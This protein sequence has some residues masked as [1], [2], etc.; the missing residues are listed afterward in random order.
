MVCASPRM[1]VIPADYSIHHTKNHQITLTYAPESQLAVERRE[2]L[3]GLSRHGRQ[4]FRFQ[5]VETT[6]YHAPDAT[7]HYRLP[8]LTLDSFK[9]RRG[10]ITFRAVRKNH[11][12]GLA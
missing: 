4:G 3:S 5:T 7:V 6:R 9:Q 10:K 1:S 8:L 11:H 12:D 2:S